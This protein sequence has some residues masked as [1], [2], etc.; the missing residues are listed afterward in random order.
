MHLKFSSIPNLHITQQ[1]EKTQIS[2]KICKTPRN[3]LKLK[4]PSITYLEGTDLDL[5][6]ERCC[7][8]PPLA[9]KN[10]CESSSLLT[11]PET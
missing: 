1:R 10:S 7:R 6:L 4:I 9:S 3:Y 2:K 5:D 8:N 11:E